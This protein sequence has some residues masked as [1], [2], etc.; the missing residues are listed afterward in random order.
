MIRGTSPREK[1][2]PIDESPCEREIMSSECLSECR[3]SFCE[4]EKGFTEEQ[5]KR[6][7]GRCLRC[8]V[9]KIGRL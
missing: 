4:T 7:A 8:D 5:V 2:K 6:E 1:T 9:L 3:K